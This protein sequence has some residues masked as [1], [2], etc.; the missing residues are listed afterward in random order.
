MSR[1]FAGVKRKRNPSGGVAGVQ[2]EG[3]TSVAPP[4]PVDMVWT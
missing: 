2:A 4:A 1:R 3:S